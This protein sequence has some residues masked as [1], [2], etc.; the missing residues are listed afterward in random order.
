M[1]AV[2]TG[3]RSVSYVRAP[4]DE[5][6]AVTRHAAEFASSGKEGSA[7]ADFFRGFGDRDTS[8]SQAVNDA[9]TGMWAGFGGAQ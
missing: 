2:S 4:E 3:R 6:G 7:G 8:S 5:H 9:Y 1:S